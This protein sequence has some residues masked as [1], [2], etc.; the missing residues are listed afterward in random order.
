M[1]LC[2]FAVVFCATT[3]LQI[4]IA[5]YFEATVTSL[6]P[7][8]AQRY[9]ISSLSIVFGKVIR[10]LRN[11]G[12]GEDLSLMGGELKNIRED[13][14]TNRTARGRKSRRRRRGPIYYYNNS[15]HRSSLDMS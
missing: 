9:A 3:A 15:N 13:T 4:A 6:F 5:P 8:K 1:R 10:T 14:I 7:S 11:Y 2:K 12:L